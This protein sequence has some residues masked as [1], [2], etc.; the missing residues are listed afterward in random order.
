VRT[1]VFSVQ[2]ESDQE[3]P[4]V[5]TRGDWSSDAWTFFDVGLDAV[6]FHGAEDEE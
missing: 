3:V 2:V 6:W 4:E 1:L 5:G